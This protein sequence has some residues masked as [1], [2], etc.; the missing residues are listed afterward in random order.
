MGRIK[1][2]IGVLFTLAGGAGLAEISV[3]NHGC[4]AL[5][6]LMFAFGLAI[7]VTDLMN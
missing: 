5:C 3:S 6:T 1:H 4:F 2:G 7:C